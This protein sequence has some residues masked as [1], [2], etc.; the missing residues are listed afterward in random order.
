MNVSVSDFLTLFSA[1]T[2]GDWFW[3]T[4]PSPILM[5]AAYIA[6]STSTILAATWPSSEV[7]GIYTIGLGLANPYLLTLYIWIYCRVWWFPR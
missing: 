1:R 7:D 3:S 5:A 4:A 2:G 6:L